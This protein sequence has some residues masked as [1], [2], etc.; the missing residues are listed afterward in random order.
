MKP[1]EDIYPQR[2]AA[3]FDEKGRPFHFLFYTARPHYYE[4]LHVRLILITSWLNA[5]ISGILH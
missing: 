1:P 2:K 4:V 5:Q 3:E